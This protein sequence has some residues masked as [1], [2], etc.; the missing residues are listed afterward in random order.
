MLSLCRQCTVNYCREELGTG[1]KMALE[2]RPEDTLQRLSHRKPGRDNSHLILI[3]HWLVTR[4]PSGD[5]SKTIHIFPYE[6]TTN[7]KLWTELLAV[8]RRTWHMQQADTVCVLNRWQHFFAWNDIMASVFKVRHYIQ[9][10]KPSI[11]VYLLEEQS[12]QISS[13][14]DFK[15]QSLRLVL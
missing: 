12:C 3:L 8:S 7:Q 1:E 13:Q 14:S 9:N 5:R 10:P 6:C 11:D 15:R 2:A 4:E